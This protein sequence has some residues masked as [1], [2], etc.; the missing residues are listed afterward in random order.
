MTGLHRGLDIVVAW[1]LSPVYFVAVYFILA[2]FL[3]VVGYSVAEIYFF[4]NFI[5]IFISSCGS[6]LIQISSSILH[7]LQI[8]SLIDRLL[9]GFEYLFF[10]LYYR[11]FIKAITI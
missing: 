2:F 5:D 10:F 4:L 8:T 6:I 9:L 7:I 3:R 1:I 11:L